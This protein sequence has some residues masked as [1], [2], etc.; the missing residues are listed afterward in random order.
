MSTTPLPVQST[1]LTVGE[2]FSYLLPRLSD[3][4]RQNLPAWPP[5]VFGLM[6]ALIQRSGAYLQALENW[7][8]KRYT[9]PHDKFAYAAWAAELGNEWRKNSLFQQPAPALIHE[10]WTIFFKRSFHFSLTQFQEDQYAAHDAL[11]LMA[12]S[13]EA[14]RGLGASLNLPLDPESALET[15]E[16]WM[17]SNSEQSGLLKFQEEL[18]PSRISILPKRRTPQSGLNVRS[19]SHHLCA[20]EGLEANPNWMVETTIDEPTSQLNL[21]LFPW[22]FE[23]SPAAFKAVSSRKENMRNMSPDFGFFTY[24]PPQN[25][26]LLQLFKLAFKLDTEEVGKLHGAVLP[27]ASVT[28][29]E[30]TQLSRFAESQGCFLIAGVGSPATSKESPGTNEVRYAARFGNRAVQRKHHRWQLN[31]SQILSYQLGS[32]L[33]PNRKWWEY[34]SLN[35]REVMIQQLNSWLSFVPLVCEDLARPDPVGEIVR[36]VGPDLVIALLMDGPQL[37]TRWTARNAMTLADDPGCSV[38]TLTSLGMIAL[39]NTRQPNPRV[40]P[41]L[42][43]DPLGG[44]Q[45]IEFP[46]NTEAAVL[47]LTPRSRPEWT[48]DGRLD[49]ISNQCP[50]LSGIR[51]LK[52]R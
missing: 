47:T 12:L 40:I 25:R 32:S 51:F 20:I 49:K 44:A 19:L 46:P 3:P 38:L 35:Q 10:I 31:D 4:K 33:D 7:P 23:L 13:D 50:T 1:S 6:S 45:E 28:S 30:W 39:S 18:D 43:K 11:I 52:L 41:A 34:I 21:L 14:S 5:D 42:Y 36:S 9:I 27:E 24:D 29:K 17:R 48:A 22:P 15:F 26:N 2:L 8:P 37:Q 16:I